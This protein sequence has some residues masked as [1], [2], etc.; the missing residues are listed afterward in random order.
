MKY[1]LNWSG[2]ADEKYWHYIAKYCLPSWS[3]LPGDKF[4]VTES[5]SVKVKN[6]NTV[7]WNTVVDADAN[8]L[9]LTVK[10]KQINFWRKMQAQ[11]WAAKNLR[12]CDFLIL[13]DTDI[14]VLNFDAAAFEK[15]LDEFL[16]SGKLWAIGESQRNQ[17]DSGHII[18]NT[19]HH[20]YAKLIDEYEDYWNSGK[21]FDLY[22]PYD[23]FVVQALMN[24]Y[25]Y[26]KL[27]NRDYGSGLHVYEIGTVH[28]GS[29]QPKADRAAWTDDGN[30]LLKKLLSERTIKIYKNDFTPST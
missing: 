9:K 11:V 21:I 26:F 25:D 15:I 30:S 24:T 29:K 10:T 18:L 19:K 2:L 20:N 28:W 5:E 22:R 7:D 13:L 3:N 12:D 6:L 27:R 8:F 23:G 17:I 14:E 4:I 16:A 1:K